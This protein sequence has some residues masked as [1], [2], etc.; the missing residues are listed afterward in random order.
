MNKRCQKKT[1]YAWGQVW[2]PTCV[3]IS[4]LSCSLGELPLF[5]LTY[6]VRSNSWKTKNIVYLAIDRIQNYA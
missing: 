3:N 6:F 5:G 4:R 2:T 1:K